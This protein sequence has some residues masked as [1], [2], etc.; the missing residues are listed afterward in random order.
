MGLDDVADFIGNKNVRDL[1][2]SDRRLMGGGRLRKRY[3]GSAKKEDKNDERS[4]P[5]VPHGLMASRL[6]SVFPGTAGRLPTALS[7]GF[8]R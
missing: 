7:S 8:C 5:Y 6:L 1:E 3:L 2:V 4:F